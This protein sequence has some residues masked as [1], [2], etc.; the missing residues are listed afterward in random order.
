M[1][2]G[3]NNIIHY[4]ASI[5]PTTRKMEWRN[6]RRLYEDTAPT[7]VANEFRGVGNVIWEVLEY[8][9]KSDKADIGVR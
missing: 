1:N 9:D 2:R 4:Y 7:I 3:G 6:G 5:N 8:E